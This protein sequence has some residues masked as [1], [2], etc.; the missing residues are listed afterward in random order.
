M[1]RISNSELVSGIEGIGRGYSGSNRVVVD[2]L[3]SRGYEFEE[4]EWE[5]ECE[6]LSGIEVYLVN[7]Y[8]IMNVNIEEYEV[9][10]DILGL[11]RCRLYGDRGSNGCS[12][13]MENGGGVGYEM[14][15]RTLGDVR[16]ELESRE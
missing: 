6:Y 13:R 8:T 3:D 16:R 12:Y 7:L 1:E 15:V 5:M 10:M 11:I 9:V 2:L 4:G 14:H